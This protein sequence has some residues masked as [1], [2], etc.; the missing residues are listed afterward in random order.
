MS[1]RREHWRLLRPKS[2]SEHFVVS[3]ETPS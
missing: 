3:A 2:D 1:L